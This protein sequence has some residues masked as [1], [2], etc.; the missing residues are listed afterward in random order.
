MWEEFICLLSSILALHRQLLQVE[1]QKER[2]LVEVRLKDLQELVKR[3]QALAEAVQEKEERRKE[4]L[5][6]LLAE[7]RIAGNADKMLDLVRFCDE[8]TGQRIVGIHTEL[9]DTLRVLTKESKRNELLARQA[10]G[11]FH[12]KLNVVSGAQVEPTYASQGAERVTTTRSCL[13]FE[14]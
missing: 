10:L 12:Y 8:K 4:L 5:P 2:A 11:V 1:E 3:E 7:N 13:N 14:A 6:R 9:K